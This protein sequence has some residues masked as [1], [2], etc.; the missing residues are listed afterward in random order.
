VRVGRY[1]CPRF[2]RLRGCQHTERA[3]IADIR[4][5]RREVG[6]VQHV[7]KRRLEAHMPVFPVDEELRQ[8]TADCDRARRFE[9]SN[10]RI[11]SPS[12]IE[13]RVRKSI[14]VEVRAFDPR[15]ETLGIR[16]GR[17]NRTVFSW[18]RVGLVIGYAVGRGQ[19]RP[20]FQQRDG[21]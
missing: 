13:G 18:I 11:P 3:G 16:S 8:P 20:G 10:A 7:G 9:D 14:D 5:R 2:P 12:S 6:V 17:T 21:V 1:G 4:C 15:S 19:V